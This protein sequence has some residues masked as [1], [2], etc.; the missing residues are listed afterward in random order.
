M[1]NR[2]D[3]INGF[4]GKANGLYVESHGLSVFLPKFWGA[5]GFSV[6]G[7]R[8]FSPH[9]TSGKRMGIQCLKSFLRDQTQLIES[10]RI[11][12][13]S[14]CDRDIA[15]GMTPGTNMENTLVFKFPQCRNQG[16][17]QVDGCAVHGIRVAFDLDLQRLHFQPNDTRHIGIVF[18][19]NRNFGR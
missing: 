11:G 18:P 19:H 3:K 12:F 2:I 5:I 9:F 7:S 6:P 4:R 8:S 13:V 17:V 14:Y 15:T 1:D 10:S 16:T